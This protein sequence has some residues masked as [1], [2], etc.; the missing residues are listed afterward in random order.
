MLATAGSGSPIA[1]NSSW[2]GITS[3]E[4]RITSQ[5]GNSSRVLVG[6]SGAGSV[7]ARGVVGE[8]CTTNNCGSASLSVSR[9]LTQARISTT[10]VDVILISRQGDGGQDAND[11][12]NNHQLDQ[13]EA[14]L[15]LRFHNSLPW[16]V[17][18][19][20]PIADHAFNMPTLKT[21]AGYVHAKPAPHQTTQTD[22]LRHF[23]SP[24][25]AE[26]GSPEQLGYKARIS[27]PWHGFYR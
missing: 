16:D 5:S 10:A 27:A 25:Q 14:F 19:Q 24:R 26:F 13:G 3:S 1:S 18:R 15:H 8:S 23:L 11:S 12:N 6:C 9:S 20:M 21:R 4:G 7:R 2:G 22:T 17:I